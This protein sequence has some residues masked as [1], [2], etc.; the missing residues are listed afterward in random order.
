MENILPVVSVIE[1]ESDTVDCLIMT[2]HQIET[3]L[4]YIQPTQESVQD[5]SVL[6][7]MKVNLFDFC[8][9]QRE[10]INNVYHTK[11]FQKSNHHQPQTLVLLYSGELAHLVIHD[12]TETHDAD[13]HVIGGLPEVNLGIGWS[14]ERLPFRLP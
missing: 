8:L 5:L 10:C 7:I 2:K 4:K 12:R 6:S 14:H 11:R 13:V 9:K 3:V 1:T